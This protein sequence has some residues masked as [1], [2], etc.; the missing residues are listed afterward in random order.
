VDN[1][2]PFPN[3]DHSAKSPDSTESP[4]LD[5]VLHGLNDTQ[6]SRVLDLVVTL[7]LDQ[8][9]PLFLI[10]IATGQ[11]QLLLED[12]P[13]DFANLFATLLEELDLWKDQNVQTLQQMT[14]EAQAVQ[15]LT[16]SCKTLQNNVSSLQGI[17]LTLIKELEIS[18]QNNQQWKSSFD[19]LKRDLI[20]SLSTHNLRNTPQS[21]SVPL[22]PIKPL[23]RQASK[24]PMTTWGGSTLLLGLIT[25]SFLVSS[26]QFMQ[27]RHAQS[28]QQRQLNHLI[29]EQT[30]RNCIESLLPANGQDCQ[31]L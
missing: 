11:L 1:V 22:T 17:L 27:I 26:F 15:G 6:R 14:L 2:H 13:L 3:T 30:R 5:K 20:L 19:S 9:D 12:A 18:N 23:S 21:S 28:I 4:L 7:G 8:N 25:G 31:N 29:D 10:A 24:S 16:Q